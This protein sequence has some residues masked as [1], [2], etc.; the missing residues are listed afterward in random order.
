MRK[1]V[2]IE[3]IIGNLRIVE[4]II[5]SVT[6][7]IGINQEN[8]G[9]VLVSALEAVNNAIIHG[10]KSDPSKK[11]DIEIT[12]TNKQ[13]KIKVTD[14]GPGFKPENVPDP[15][16]PKNLEALNGRG[17]FLMS[18]LADDIKFSKKGNSVKMTFKNIGD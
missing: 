16:E 7:E 2:I 14:E 4:K 9:K 8:Y 13:L 5:D 6:N 3:S 18:R 12:F 15:T 11:V 17:I 10:N 1:Q